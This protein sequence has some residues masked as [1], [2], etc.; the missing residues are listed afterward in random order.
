M[1]DVMLYSLRSTAKNPADYAIS[2]EA[3]TM[4]PLAIML[5]KD[6]PSFKK[7]VDT[8]IARIITQGEISP[9]TASGSNRRSRRTRTTS[10]CP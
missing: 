7:L 3:L 8:E 2:R 9:S 10:R 6:D 4:E 5:R 1:D